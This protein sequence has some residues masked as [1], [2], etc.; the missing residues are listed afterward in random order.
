MNFSG[1]W[2]NNTMW[3]KPT[4]FWLLLWW[5]AGTA[6]SRP[7]GA[8][9]TFVPLRIGFRA[10]RE[11]EFQSIWWGG[12][13]CLRYLLHFTRQ[14]GSFAPPPWRIEPNPAPPL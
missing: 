9:A 7:L 13:S 8:L 5:I 14:T 10:F 11:L 6:A 1:G 3:P 12:H 2:Q 4:G